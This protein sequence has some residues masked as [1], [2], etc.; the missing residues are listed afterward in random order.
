MRREL[1]AGPAPLR[2]GTLLRAAL[3]EKGADITLFGGGIWDF[4]SFG[5]IFAPGVH[6]VGHGQPLLTCKQLGGNCNFEPDHEVEVEG[7]SFQA[8]FGPG[9]QAQCFGL[10]RK[11]APDDML[12]TIYDCVFVGGSFSL[13]A[14]TGLRAKFK[15]YRSMISAG[16]WGVTAGGSSGPDA[17]TIELFDCIVKA[18]R[19]AF[20]GA[21]ASQ[22]Q[23]TAGLVARGGKIIMHGGSIEVVGA[24][25]VSATCALTTS[26]PNPPSTFPDWPSIELHNVARKVVPN[27]SVKFGECETQCGKIADY[28]PKVS[29]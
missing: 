27:G 23:Q 24:T 3:Q 13:Y 6:L 10:Q 7:V 5:V 15:V 14:W 25:G 20:P 18:D 28:Q 1:E 26:A 4:N 19:I 16:G 12:V 9:L 29:A 21:D 17:Q 8:P 2:N 11:G 22:G